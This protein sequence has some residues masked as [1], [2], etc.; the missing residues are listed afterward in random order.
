MCHGLESY[1]YF[2]HE[3]VLLLK[4]KEEEK[5]RKLSFVVFREW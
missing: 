1:K 3:S 2:T 5:V 4:H